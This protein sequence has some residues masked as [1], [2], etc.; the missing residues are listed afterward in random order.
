MEAKAIAKTIRISPRKV[1]LVID[2]VRGKSVGEALSILHLTPNG[3]GAAVEKVVKSAL[4]NAIN[5]YSMN[6]EKLY[7]KEIYA[8]DGITM[9][10]KYLPRA[11]GSADSLLKRTSNVTV[12]LAEKE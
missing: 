12:V 1:R 2:L 5:N 9:K 10:T 3:A 6:K 7:V 4:A 11:K 8:N